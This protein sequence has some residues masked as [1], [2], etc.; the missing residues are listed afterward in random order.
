MTETDQLN[1][2]INALESEAARLR[3]HEMR[4]AFVQNNRCDLIHIPAID[5]EP[6]A[7]ELYQVQKRLESRDFTGRPKYALLAGGP[8]VHS[9]IDH[10]IEAGHKTDPEA[11]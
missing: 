4:L 1:S 11:A 8:T 9:A 7:E 6:G 3:L 5:Q 2:R 10:A